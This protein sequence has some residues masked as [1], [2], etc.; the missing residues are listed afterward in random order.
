M[1]TTRQPGGWTL[2]V[3]NDLGSTLD[4]TITA[5]ADQLEHQVVI[6]TTSTVTRDALIPAPGA[7]ERWLVWIESLDAFTRWNG[8]AWIWASQVRRTVQFNT[9]SL[10]AGAST[11]LVIPY[12]VTMPTAP[13]VTVNFWQPF[14]WSL[15]SLSSYSEASIKITNPTGST[16]AATNYHRLT[17]MSS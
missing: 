17:A 9:P 16:I 3:G 1:T 8:T 15:V 11:N 13:I 6:S 2:P 10:A 5:W 12:G 4:D 7:S 14:V